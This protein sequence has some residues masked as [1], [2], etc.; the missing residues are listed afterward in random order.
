MLSMIKNKNCAAISWPKIYYFFIK[1]CNCID[2]IVTFKNKTKLWDIKIISTSIN[3]YYLYYVHET[4]Q[5]NIHIMT[6]T[7]KILYLT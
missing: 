4:V 6:M 3:Y 1:L 5:H 2:G 7:M